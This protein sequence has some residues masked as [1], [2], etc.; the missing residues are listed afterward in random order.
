MAGQQIESAQALDR[1]A[2]N[3]LRTGRA[4]VTS[5]TEEPGLIKEEK[6]QSTQAIHTLILVEK[7]HS[8]RLMLF[9]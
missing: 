2:R 8:L 7:E 9:V 5:C 4:R 6:H 1:N 3:T